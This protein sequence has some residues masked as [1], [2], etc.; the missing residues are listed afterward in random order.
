M[1]PGR[2]IAQSSASSASSV[3]EFY[4]VTLCSVAN[5]LRVRLTRP[6][7]DHLHF[8]RREL[9]QFRGRAGELRERAEMHRNDVLHAEQRARDRG[10]LRAHRVDV[11]DRK[12]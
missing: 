2:R 1:Q 8:T 9:A 4:S 11:A 5:V 10:L 12:K 3:V 6:E 7:L